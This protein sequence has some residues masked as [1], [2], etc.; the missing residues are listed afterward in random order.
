MRRSPPFHTKC[1]ALIE[2]ARRQGCKVELRDGRVILVGPRGVPV[3]LPA[4]SEHSQIDDLYV[5]NAIRLLPL[6]G[7]QIDEDTLRRTITDWRPTPDE[8]T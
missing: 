2:E 3:I 6:E 4:K 7:F 5:L 1:G 8:E